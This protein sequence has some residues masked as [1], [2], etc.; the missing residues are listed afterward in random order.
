MQLVRRNLSTLVAR[1]ATKKRDVKSSCT[2]VRRLPANIK[3][4][5]P[6]HIPPTHSYPWVA[7]PQ[8]LPLTLPLTYLYRTP[9]LTP[10]IPLPMPLPTPS[11]ISTFTRIPIPATALPLRLHLALKEYSKSSNLPD[12]GLGCRTCGICSSNARWHL[13]L[14]SWHEFFS[15]CGT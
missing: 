13:V 9:T 2:G 11:H 4:V 12:A 15:Q 1:N 7:L 10:T 6:V 3:T 8:P 5:F 14:S